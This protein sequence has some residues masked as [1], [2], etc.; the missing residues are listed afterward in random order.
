MII[1]A[2]PR[3]GPARQYSSEETEKAIHA[4][5]C[6]L[7]QYSAFPQIN[8]SFSSCPDRCKVLE[9]DLQE[10]TA[11]HAEIAEKSYHFRAKSLCVLCVLRGEERDFSS[12][13]GTD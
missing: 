11:E 1:A 3:F 9:E 10:F 4:K 12:L 2:A 5:H 7:I 8:S 13:T 6:F